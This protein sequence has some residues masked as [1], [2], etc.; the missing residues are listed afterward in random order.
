VPRRAPS[1]AATTTTTTA[2]GGQPVTIAFAGDIH[3]EGVLHAKLA[4]NP[5]AVLAPIAPV[6][7]SAD[8]TVANLETAVTD[9]R[10]PAEEFTFRAP[11]T[12]L[13]ALARG[14]D[15]ASMANNHGLDYGPSLQDSLAARNERPPII[16]IGNSDRSLRLTA[17]SRAS[18][19]R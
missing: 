11:A 15:V 7:G 4:A 12:A 18:A 14:I 5:S 1:T 10:T 8:L 16:R 2:G 13:T 19:S 17:T 6:L 3:F 9:R